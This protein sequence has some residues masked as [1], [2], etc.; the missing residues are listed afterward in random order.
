MVDNESDGRNRSTDDRQTT[1]RTMLKAGGTALVGGAGIAAA[2]GSAAAVSSWDIEVIDIGGGIWGGGSPDPL[3]IE[4]ELFVFVHGWFGD[5]TVASQASDVATSMEDAGYEA[6][7]YAAIEWDA[8]TINFPAAES[9]TEEVGEELAELLEDFYDDG[10]GD[11]RLI[12]HSLGGRVVLETV[13]HIDDG[14]SVETVAPLGAAADGDMVCNGGGGLFGDN[15][16]DGIEENADEVR[17]YHSEDDSTVGAAYGG[18]FG[19][20]LGTDGSGC[21]NDVADNYTDVDVTDSV[22]SHLGFLGD[23]AVGADLADAAGVDVDDGDNGWG[24]W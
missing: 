6:D 24:W 1:R 19:A 9:E 10:G 22:G 2:S 23:E 20:A 15:W 11:V 13:N 21:P 7:E 17:N 16:Y 4:D 18:F 8:T 12:G 3:P 14:Y 5:S